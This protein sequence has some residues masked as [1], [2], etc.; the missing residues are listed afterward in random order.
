MI[1]I[2]GGLVA[3]I[4]ISLVWVARQGSMKK[5]LR[6]FD[7]G[8][9]CIVCHKTNMTIAGGN[10]RC[11]DCLHVSDLAAMQAA[12]VT[13]DQIRDATRPSD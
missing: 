13:D 9:R 2:V 6:E 5:R 11:G 1:K 8:T 10:A 7:N 4:I 12:V 3:L